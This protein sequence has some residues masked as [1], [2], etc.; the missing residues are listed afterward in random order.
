VIVKRQKT[1]ILAAAAASAVF[2]L[3]G[4]SSLDAPPFDPRALS[5]NQREAATG[6]AG[7]ERITLPEKL[8]S[9]ADSDITPKERY[10]NESLLDPLSN[11]PR[12]VR[13]DLR[14]AIQRA[15]VNNLDVRVASYTPAIEETRF[16]EADARF[17][18]TAIVNASVERNRQSTSSANG[19]PLNSDFRRDTIEAGIRQLLDTGGEYSLTYSV[20]HIDAGNGDPSNILGNATNGYFHELRLQLTQPLLR[21]AGRDVNRARITINRNNQQIAVL[22]FRNQ[23]EDSLQELER[24]YWQLVQAQRE[25]EIQQELLNNTINTANTLF[26]RRETDVNRLQISQANA[27]IETRRAQLVRARARVADLSDDLKRL[28]ADG[29]ISVGGPELILPATPPALQ[30]VL[31][32]PS[33]LIDTALLNRFELG[34]QQLRI[35]SAMIALGVA[36]NNELPRFDLTGTASAQGFSNGGF[37]SG[38]NE[39]FDIDTAGNYQGVLSVGFQFE[40]PLGNRAAKAIFRRAQ[41]QYL[42]AND[43]YRQLIEQIITDVTKAAREV[44]TTWTEIVR[45]RQSAFAAE[46]ALQAVQIREDAG[47]ALSPEF[48]DLKLRQQEL[49]AQSKRD[50]AAAISNYNIA[51]AGLERVKGTLLKYNNVVMEEAA[52]PKR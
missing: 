2:S 3:V 9:I 13:I 27:S 26:Q 24:T 38:F 19:S 17:D 45:T 46:D 6:L 7:T 23:L 30:Q 4:C 31:L 21:D 35:D 48:V 29:T 28:M 10:Q 22:D 12:V 8:D 16:T 37:G 36:K 47:E 5:A 42:Q 11:Q 41:L 33:E 14:E 50:E 49:V 52:L 43:S 20:N 25:V 51:L 40:Y 1:V 44:E 34:Q 32:A 15:V 18:P 39:A